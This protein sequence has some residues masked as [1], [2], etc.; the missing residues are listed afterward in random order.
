MGTEMKE[1]S[2]QSLQ[3]SG[4]ESALSKKRLKEMSNVARRI[5]LNEETAEALYGW[6]V[7]LDKGQVD[8]EEFSSF[9]TRICQA[10][11]RPFLGEVQ[12]QKLWQDLNPIR[13]QQTS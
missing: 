10:G 8:E 13:G 3:E 12:T 11:S 6:Y 4:D 1:G 2:L 5:G 9:L 7:R